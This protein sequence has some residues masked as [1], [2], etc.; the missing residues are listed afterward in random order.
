L[1]GKKFVRVAEPNL[2]SPS[3][4]MELWRILCLE[5][6]ASRRW[7]GRK[8]GRKEGKEGSDGMKEEETALCCGNCE[9]FK[10]K[11]KKKKTPSY[12]HNTRTQFNPNFHYI[13]KISNFQERKFQKYQGK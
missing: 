12:V 5:K 9:F 4:A 3:S 8:E 10:K 13:Q 11:K 7:R 1:G 2:Q 6:F